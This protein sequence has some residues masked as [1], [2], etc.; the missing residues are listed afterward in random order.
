MSIHDS[1]FDYDHDDDMDVYDLL[2]NC[3]SLTVETATQVAN[4]IQRV[5]DDAEAAHSYEDKLM[6]TFV[7][8]IAD[9]LLTDM[10]TIKDI[11]AVIKSI[12]NIRFTR[13]CA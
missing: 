13:Y 1:D 11:A 3:V 6:S 7:K 2:N 4:Y 12:S 5:S 8:Q 10:V 9:G